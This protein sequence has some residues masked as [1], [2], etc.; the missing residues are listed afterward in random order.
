MM[1]RFQALLSTFVC[2]YISGFH[3]ILAALMV[4]LRQLLPDERV[5]LPVGPDDMYCSPRHRTHIES[6]I[7]PP[8]LELNG[9]HPMTWRAMIVTPTSPNA[10]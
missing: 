9:M 5:P 6:H 8:L 10:N 7:E 2:R 1:N 3:G 4:A